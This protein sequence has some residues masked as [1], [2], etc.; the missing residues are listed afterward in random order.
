MSNMLVIPP[1]RQPCPGKSCNTCY[2][3]THPGGHGLDKVRIFPKSYGTDRGLRTAIIQTQINAIDVYRC[4]ELTA[5]FAPVRHRRTP[6]IMVAPFLESKGYVLE[7]R[8]I[9][10]REPEEDDLHRLRGIVSSTCRYCMI[11]N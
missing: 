1:P 10:S 6:W 4:W 11:N 3:I 2:V 8:S 9:I 5:G 7:D